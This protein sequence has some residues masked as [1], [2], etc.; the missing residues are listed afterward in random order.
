MD[1]QRQILEAL[2]KDDVKELQRLFDAPGGADIAAVILGHNGVTA[3]HVAAMWNRPEAIRWLM[4]HG[5]DLKAKDCDGFTPLHWAAYC[6]QTEIVRQLI[7]KNA[8]IK[9]KDCDGGTAL[10]Q[11]AFRGQTE[12]VKLLLAKGSEK[13]TKDKEGKTALDLAREQKHAEVVRLLEAAQIT[14]SPNPPPRPETPPQ[15]LPANPVPS[16]ATNDRGFLYNPANWIAPV[17]AFAAGLFGISKLVKGGI[18]TGTVLG[19]LALAG[20]ATLVSQA[21]T[22]T[23]LFAPSQA[24]HL[25]PSQDNITEGHKASRAEHPSPSISGLGTGEVQTALMQLGCRQSCAEG[26]SVL[27]NAALPIRPASASQTV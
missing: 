12:I 19:A 26:A 18:G 17:V 14:P 27:P 2:S 8:D 16:P 20:G 10:H 7:D 24:G 15:P 9:A 22:H 6:G 23:G 11:A 13:D 25:P 1:R 4:E 5:A 3:L 21:V